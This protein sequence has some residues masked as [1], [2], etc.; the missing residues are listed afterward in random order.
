M[1]ELVL[2]IDRRDVSISLE[3]GTICVRRPNHPPEFVPLGLLGLVVIHGNPMVGSS[4]LRTLGELAIPT[5][6]LPTKGRGTGA[7]ISPALGT[8]I[9]VRVAQHRAA[10]GERR[11]AIARGM[12]WEKLAAYRALAQKHGFE[13][14][15]ARIEAAMDRLDDAQDAI[16]LQGLE[17]TGASAWWSALAERLRAQWGFYGR[18]RRPPRDPVNALLSLG[19]TLVAAEMEMAIHAY[20]LDPALGFLHEVVPGRHTLVLDLMEPLRAGVDAFVLQSLE[21][22]LLEPADF[23]CSRRDGCRLAESG[24]RIFYQ[25][26]AGAR[27]LWPDPRGGM[28]GLPDACRRQARWL[29]DILGPYDPQTGEA[30]HG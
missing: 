15:V 25:A 27:V 13:E 28:M 4:V 17:G 16:T 6:L 11:L 29:R 14:A 9:A 8:S 5:V 1:K 10:R 20:G 12:V 26:W 2:V 7:W 19:Y 21:G 18:N 3:G 23:R 22:G 30:V 24:K